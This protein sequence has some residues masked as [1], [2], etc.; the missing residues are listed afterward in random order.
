MIVN[1][2]FTDTGSDYDRPDE[3][4]APPRQRK[5]KIYIFLCV[6]LYN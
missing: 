1:I 4:I 2:D 3:P 6:T 5:G